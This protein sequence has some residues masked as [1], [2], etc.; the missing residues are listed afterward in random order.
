MSIAP[1]RVFHDE[2][3]AY[4][5]VEDLVWPDG[6]VCPHCSGNGRVGKMKGQSTRIGTYKCY[7]CRKPFTVKLGTLVESSHVP[8]HVWLKAV[9][10]IAC[11][12]H[13]VSLLELQRSTG[14]TLRTAWFIAER[15]RRAM[16]APALTYPNVGVA[17]RSTS[18]I[19]HVPMAE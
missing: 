8:L 16:A 6:P 7:G 19:T 13:R 11:S 17:S 4:R 1:A 10:L 2:R 9:Y 12:E 5:L 15:V 14:V 3:A 18:A